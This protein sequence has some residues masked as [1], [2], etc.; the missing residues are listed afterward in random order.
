[1]RNASTK[2]KTVCCQRRLG[3]NRYYGHSSQSGS[4]LSEDYNS[5]YLELVMKD[6]NELLAEYEETMRSLQKGTAEFQASIRILKRLRPAIRKKYAIEWRDY[7]ENL[8]GKSRQ[9]VDLIEDAIEFVDQ[10]Q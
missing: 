7:L 9:L 2:F 4:Y 6:W 10:G 3:L 5:L 1:M 8:L